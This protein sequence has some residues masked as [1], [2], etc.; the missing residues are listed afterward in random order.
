MAFRFFPSQWNGLL[1]LAVDCCW[2]YFSFIWAGWTSAKVTSFWQQQAF[3]P[4]YLAK[5]AAVEAIHARPLQ[6]SGA[7]M[8]ATRGWWKIPGTTLGWFAD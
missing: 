6:P 8:A 4:S 1:H 7:L 2:E 5:G 3:Q